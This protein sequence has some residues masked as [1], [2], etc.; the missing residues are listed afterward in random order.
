MIT[1]RPDRK[2]S[3]PG[4]GNFGNYVGAGGH[5]PDH[6]K[7]RDRTRRDAGFF[8][9]TWDKFRAKLLQLNPICQ[10]VVNGKRCTRPATV[11]HHII[12][13]EQRKDLAY[14]Q[15]NVVAVCA[16]CHP[17]PADRDQGKFV[18]TLWHEF[19]STEPLPVDV[20][21]PGDVPPRDLVLWMVSERLAALHRTLD[22][23]PV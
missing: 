10:R 1:S 22:R 12:E 18:P 23:I 5:C 16:S 4:C 20:C 14:S 19:M 8:N 13:L 7:Q 11:A 15:L 2:C 6:S 21:K 9:A 3:T 17:R